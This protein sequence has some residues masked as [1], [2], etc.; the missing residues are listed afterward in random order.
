M[1]KW[2]LNSNQYEIMKWLSC[3]ALHA[4]GVFYVAIA[5]YWN[6]PYAES[7]AGTCDAL[8]LFVGTL[9]GI[10]SKHFY[11]NKVDPGTDEEGEE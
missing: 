5:H 3:I 9:I 6:L 1:K 10:S 7:V 8:G 11:G 4:I 2:T